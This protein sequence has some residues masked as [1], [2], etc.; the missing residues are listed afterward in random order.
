MS[1]TAHWNWMVR[2]ENVR[3][4]DFISVNPGA[5]RNLS[6]EVVGIMHLSHE[7]LDITVANGEV[8]TF[9]FGD[10]VYRER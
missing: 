8:R 7:L 4:G 9:E 10:L 5:Y 6:G 1:L 3:I 2:V